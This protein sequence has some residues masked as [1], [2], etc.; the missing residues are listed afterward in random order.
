MITSGPPL[1]LATRRSG[2]A[3]AKIDP[4]KVDPIDG[5]TDKRVQAGLGRL[6]ELAKNVGVVVVDHHMAR[7]D[8]VY[9]AVCD[10]VSRGCRGPL[11][12]RQMSNGQA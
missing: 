1:W 12:P 11:N 6:I 8:I 5:M 10:A 7:G 3:G 2:K 9:G 4:A